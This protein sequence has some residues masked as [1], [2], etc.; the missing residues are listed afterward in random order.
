[1]VSKALLHWHDRNLGR[2]RM[3]GQVCCQQPADTGFSLGRQ[4]PVMVN[5]KVIMASKDMGSNDLDP[6]EGVINKTLGT[7]RRTH[8][9]SI[10]RSRIAKER[11]EEEC[12]ENE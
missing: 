11:E 10:S 8:R 3:A 1:M 6:V 2:R 5:E 7:L 4:L 9:V 12:D